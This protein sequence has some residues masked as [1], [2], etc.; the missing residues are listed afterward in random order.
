MEQWRELISNSSL[1]VSSHY[2]LA[3]FIT[4]PVTQQ[5]TESL[6]AYWL[7]HIQG[8][9]VVSISFWERGALMEQ[10]IWHAFFF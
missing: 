7:Y 6:P 3:V 2:L 5:Q 10:F 9:T 8:A 4:Y 1:T